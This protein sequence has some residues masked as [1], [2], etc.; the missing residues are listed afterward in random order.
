MKQVPIATTSHAT[1]EE[2]L[3]TVFSTCSVHSHENFVFYQCLYHYSA[4]LSSNLVVF[5]I[6]WTYFCNIIM[7]TDGA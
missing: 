1:I 4:R 3:E 2:Q 7:M 5:Q 6:R